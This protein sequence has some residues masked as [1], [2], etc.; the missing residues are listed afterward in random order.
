MCPLSFQ[1]GES[2]AR[3]C[4]DSTVGTIWITA[5]ADI[6]V[7]GFLTLSSLTGVGARGILREG[8]SGGFFFV[9]S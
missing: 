6:P 5:A 4:Q 2:I 7:G 1:R 9:F 3:R 8:S